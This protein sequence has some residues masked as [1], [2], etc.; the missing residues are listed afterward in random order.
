MADLRAAEALVRVTAR[1]AAQPPDM[2]SDIDALFDFLVESE[3]QTRALIAYLR[4]PSKPPV[5]PAA[6]DIEFG[7]VL[8]W[9]HH[10]P[11]EVEAWLVLHPLL[12]IAYEELLKRAPPTQITRAEYEQLEAEFHEYGEPGPDG[13][14]YGY[15]KYQQLDR[16]WM[17]A[18][19]NYAL[20]LID[21]HSI[22][23]LPDK[24]CAP[25]ALTR[26]DGDAGKDPVLGIVGDWGTGYYPDENGVPCP[27]QRV[28]EQITD[29]AQSPPIDYLIHLGDTYY[30]GTD[31]RPPPD[32]EEK[33]FYHLWPDQGEGRNF[34]LNSN[35]EMYGA[36][37]GYF[38]VALQSG[39]KFAA[40][41][42][43]S[44]FAL[45][46]GPWLVLCLDSGYYS[47]AYNGR[48]MYM[49]GAIGTDALDRQIKWV[50]QFR[51]WPGPIMVMTHHTG[52]DTLTGAVTPLYA[53]VHAALQKQPTLWYWGHVHN[54]IVYDKLNDSS[55]TPVIAAEAITTRGRCCGHGAI[56]FGKAWGLE[57]SSGNTDPNILYYAHTPDPLLPDTSGPCPANP[58]V[59]NGYALVTL[60]GDGGFTEAFYETGA[61]GPVWQ[62]RWAASELE[63]G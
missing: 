55:A 54:A 59:R 11:W 38:L 47:D 48:R 21:P 15:K 30:A 43:M 17:L 40:Q 33:N 24:A 23:P 13:T 9:I 51:T 27:A 53:Q 36:A 1:A 32:E 52:C 4:N 41:H 6:G 8:Y 16:G 35:H 58:R 25:I 60:H 31:W 18:A 22:H 29:P 34:T 50:E 46:Y 49:D 39:G 19:L 10:P 28:M 37:S 56:P 20:N 42:G 62:R 12:G 2:L 45:T 61:A 63:A 7:F 3:A 57:D 44:Y 14:L 5:A 26:K